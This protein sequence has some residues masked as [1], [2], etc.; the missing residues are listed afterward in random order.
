MNEELTIHER[1]AE[2]YL[3]AKKSFNSLAELYSVYHS[4]L[5]LEADGDPD[6]EKLEELRLVVDISKI[7]LYLN[8]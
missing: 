8:S 7:K 2:R 3:S 4:N 6:A 5:I 1:A